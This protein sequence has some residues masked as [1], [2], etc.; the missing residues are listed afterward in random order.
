[1]ITLSW[2][3]KQQ[4]FYGLRWAGLCFS[5]RLKIVTWISARHRYTVTHYSM[6]N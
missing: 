3:K 2:L 6:E 4:P 1:L 5:Y